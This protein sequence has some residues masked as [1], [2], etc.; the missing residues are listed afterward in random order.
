LTIH[1]KGYTLCK[2]LKSCF[3][4]ICSFNVNS[5]F[6]LCVLYPGRF[7]FGHDLVRGRKEQ[8]K[9]ERFWWCMDMEKNILW[10]RKRCPRRLR[11]RLLQARMMYQKVYR[12]ESHSNRPTLALEHLFLS[13]K[14]WL[15]CEL[16]KGY[17]EST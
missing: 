10:G 3:L 17:R 11:C 2:F 12:A 6:Y 7:V 13:Y 5:G 4:C 15:I 1:V 16:F 9:A 14:T 8:T